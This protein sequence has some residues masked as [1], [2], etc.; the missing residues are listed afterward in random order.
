MT[1][2]DLEMIKLMLEKNYDDELILDIINK[3]I[4]SDSIEYDL[5]ERKRLK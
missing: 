3:N 4:E 5:E 1:I 2:T